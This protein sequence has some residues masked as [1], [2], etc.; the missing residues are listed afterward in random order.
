LSFGDIKNYVIEEE[1][2]VEEEFRQNLGNRAIISFGSKDDCADGKV[3]RIENSY[4]VLGESPHL[5]YVPYRN[6]A[7]VRFIDSATKV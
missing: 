7:Y 1:N 4:V 6:I 3:T 2:I 5:L